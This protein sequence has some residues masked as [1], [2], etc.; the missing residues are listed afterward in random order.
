MADALLDPTSPATVCR[1]SGALA[2]LGLESADASAACSAT[3]EQTREAFGFKWQQ[4]DT[5]ESPAVQAATR[6]WLVER[7][8]AGDPA[9]LD[10][11]LAGGDRLIVDVGCGAGN[12]A[13]ALFRH[14]L[15]DNAYLGV[16]ISSAVEVARERF[17]Q[18]DVPGD[19]LRASLFDAPIPEQSA[20]LVISEGVLHHTDST[21]R[22]FRHIAR[23]VRPGGR[24]AIYVYVRKAPVREF[25]DDLVR[26]AIRPLDDAAAWEALKPLTKLGKVLGDLNVTVD[27]P[28]AIP[29]LGIPAGPIDLQR[30]FYWYVCKMYHRPEYT[31]DEMHHVNFD[32]F[33]PLNCHRHTPDEVLRW[34]AEAGLEQE[35]L[36]VQESG[37]TLVARRPAR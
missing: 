29:F 20:D 35:H 16:D 8:L 33:R 17:A 14:H 7:Y 26:E 15:P 23:W 36:D 30:F 2:R 10:A 9:R 5:Y 34:C 6:N 37:I 11:W 31:L 12:S 24:L 21:E 3:Q 13:L 28:E 1:S 4:R 18:A 25:T 19:F 32:W 22:A 27:V